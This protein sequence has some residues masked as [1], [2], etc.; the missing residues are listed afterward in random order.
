MSCKDAFHLLCKSHV[1]CFCED[2]SRKQKGESLFSAPCPQSHGLIYAKPFSMKQKSCSW[3][4]TETSFVF[5]FCLNKTPPCELPAAVS[6]R[7]SSSHG[8]RFRFSSFTSVFFCFRL[9][10][11]QLFSFILSQGF[12]ITLSSIF[13]I[14]APMPLNSFRNTEVQVPFL[15]FDQ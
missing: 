8:P 5:Y 11:T 12:R 6:K 15:L 13:T 9:T 4:T 1:L 10:H 7:T 2:K 14:N 3:C